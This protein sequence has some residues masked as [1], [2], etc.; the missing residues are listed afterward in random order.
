[1]VMKIYIKIQQY[2]KRCLGAVSAV[3]D[4]GMGPYW[5]GVMLAV[6]MPSTT[7]LPS[8]SPLPPPSSSSSQPQ[9]QHQHQHQYNGHSNHR[10]QKKSVASSFEEWDELVLREFGCEYVDFEMRGRNE[11]GGE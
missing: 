3:R 7:P 5:D 8:P 1:M 4:R 10:G 6:G 11:F 2:I 9:H